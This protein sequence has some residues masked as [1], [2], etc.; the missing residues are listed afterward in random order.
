MTS[1]CLLVNV[2]I[3]VKT[4]EEKNT[5]YHLKGCC[6]MHNPFRSLGLQEGLRLLYTACFHCENFSYSFP[7]NFEN[8]PW[9]TNFETVPS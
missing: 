6:H 4:Q 2:E 8:K 5:G 3:P 7:V 1:F 9:Y